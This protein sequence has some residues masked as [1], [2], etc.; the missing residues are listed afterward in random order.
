MKKCYLY[1]GL[2]ILWGCSSTGEI[3]LLFPT[4]E[5]VSVSSQRISSQPPSQ[6]NHAII[7]A[8]VV[9]SNESQIKQMYLVWNDFFGSSN[10]GFDSQ[11]PSSYAN[12]KEFQWQESGKFVVSDTTSGSGVI[13]FSIFVKSSNRDSYS[14]IYT[15]A[16][17]TKTLTRF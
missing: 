9:S 3:K 11:I 16:S 8:G 7:V 1:L 10:T 14:N 5:N 6:I 15:Y 12:K 13:C 17:S 4:V 2:A